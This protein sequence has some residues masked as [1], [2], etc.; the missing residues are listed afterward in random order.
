MHT[1]NGVPYTVNLSAKEACLQDYAMCRPEVVIAAVA[2]GDMYDHDMSA[3]QNRTTRTRDPPPS[4]PHPWK[5]KRFPGPGSA[6][7]GFCH[8]DI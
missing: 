1:I 8:A 5:T 4:M 7:R 6:Y 3:T 2:M